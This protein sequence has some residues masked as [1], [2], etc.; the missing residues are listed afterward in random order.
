[1]TNRPRRLAL[2]TAVA[3]AVSVAVALPATARIRHQATGK[4]P[5]GAAKKAKSKPVQVTFWH[6]MA[7]DNETTLQ[8]LTDQ[9]NASQ[10]DVKVSLVNQT[11]YADAFTKYRAGLG[12]GELPD[13]VVCKPE[14]AEPILAF[15]A[16]HGTD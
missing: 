16:E 10:S 12:S 1:M 7:R 2:A 6:A 8:R 14:L 3:V 13:L 5:I 15:L 11:S 9:F 4:C